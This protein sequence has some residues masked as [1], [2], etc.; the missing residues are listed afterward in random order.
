[1]RNGLLAITLIILLIC[2]AIIYGLRHFLVILLINKHIT[3]T[4]IWDELLG[5]G[6]EG[7]CFAILR[8]KNI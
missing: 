3:L 7:V 8:S 2:F 6:L 5:N 4:V 1:M